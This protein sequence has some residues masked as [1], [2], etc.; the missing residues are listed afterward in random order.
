MRIRLVAGAGG[1]FLI[2]SLPF[3]L[4]APANFIHQV[5]VTQAIRN[6]GGSNTAARLADLTGLAQLTTFVGHHG[7]L[8]WLALGAVLGVIFAFFI[9]AFGDHRRRPLTAMEEIAAGS[10]LLLGFGL[11]ISPTY[12]YHYSGAI[13]PFVALLGS[14]ATVRLR[15]RLW[16]GHRHIPKKAMWAAVPVALAVLLSSAVAFQITT[17]AAPHLGDAVSDAIPSHGCVLYVSP[18]LA[19]LDNRFTSAISGCPN[20]VDWLGQERVLDNG[21]SQTA[22]DLR[23]AP[24]Q[25]AI[26]GWIKSSDAVVVNQSDP[27]WDGSTARFVHLHFQLQPG[28][29][30]GVRIFVRG[31]GTQAALGPHSRRPSEPGDDA[32]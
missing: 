5:F 25:A 4:S 24:L 22:S 32:A 28:I 14:S 11:L 21:L 6:S 8:G 27:G 16:R 30:P 29:T 31:T 13:A 15:G 3:F 26:L 7:G 12:Y 19:L 1:G 23:N 2:C 17:P 20:V 18:S 9:V 10:A